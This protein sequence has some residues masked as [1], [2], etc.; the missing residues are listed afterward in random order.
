[1]LYIP[2]QPG[3][4]RAFFLHNVITGS[5]CWR[6]I[7][8]LFPAGEGIRL[9]HSQQIAVPGLRQ[10]FLSGNAG[11]GPPQGIWTVRT[12]YDRCSVTHIYLRPE[13]IA[14]QWYQWLQINPCHQGKSTCP[15]RTLI[16]KFSF[17][18]CSDTPLQPRFPSGKLTNEI[19]PLSWYRLIM[20][21][22]MPMIFLDT[23]LPF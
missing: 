22:A 8:A 9:G 10:I 18:T 14:S 17:T 3:W 2:C 23:E 7:P 1:M 20:K 15:T 6:Y 12:L 5:S 4:S 19:W 16:I 21:L 11:P 13:N